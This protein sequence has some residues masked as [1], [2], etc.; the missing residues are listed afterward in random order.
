MRRAAPPLTP[1]GR[2]LRSRIAAREKWATTNDR[3]AATAAARRAFADRF[4]RE[5]R[6]RYGDLPADDLARRAEHLR[7]AY[8]ARLTLRSAQA[9]RA[10]AAAE[11]VA[12]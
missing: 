9:R 7:K 5:A 10:R 4:I 1:E 3:T 11:A 8:F 6:E 2:E 12:P